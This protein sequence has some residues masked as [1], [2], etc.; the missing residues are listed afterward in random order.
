MNNTSWWST[1]GGLTNNV[2]TT[3][4][5]SGSAHS[6]SIPAESTAPPRMSVDKFTDLDD[7][8]KDE[9]Y[10]GI[11]HWSCP[12]WPECP[13]MTKVHL[14]YHPEDWVRTPNLSLE[15]AV[16]ARGRLVKKGVIE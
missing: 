5:S 10:H 11:C 2:L 12:G 1:V 6:H 9:I 3:S 4:P 7:E 8:E 13:D 15:D 16:M 14:K